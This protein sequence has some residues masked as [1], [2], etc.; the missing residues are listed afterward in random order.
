MQAMFYLY[1]YVY[2]H[3]RYIFRESGHAH[4]VNERG[5]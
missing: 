5:S 3:M 4:V 1:S 2:V